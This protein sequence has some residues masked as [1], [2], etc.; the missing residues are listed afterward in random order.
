MVLTILQFEFHWNQWKK[1]EQTR[2]M[3]MLIGFGIGCP[4]RWL[5]KIRYVLPVS[6]DGRLRGETARRKGEGSLRRTGL[7]EVTLRINEIEIS[8]EITVGICGLKRRAVA[9][10]NRSLEDSS[11]PHAKRVFCHRSVALINSKRHS[12]SF[13]LAIYLISCHSI[14]EK[15]ISTLSRS[16]INF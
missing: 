9:K 13:Y 10:S 12:N 8:M 1:S 5:I 2:R 6:R 16:S 15:N 3:N 4:Y 7:V 11:S 14:H